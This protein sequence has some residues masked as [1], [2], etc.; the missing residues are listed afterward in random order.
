MLGFNK[1]I[2][3]AGAAI[4]WRLDAIAIPYM[5]LFASSWALVQ[6]SLVIAIPLLWFKITDHTDAMQDG[7]DNVVGLDEIEAVK[8]TTEHR[9]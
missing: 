7:L 3:S 8:S 9:E 4:A 6:G 2:Q 1:G 5:N